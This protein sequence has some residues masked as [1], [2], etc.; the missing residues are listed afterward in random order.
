MLTMIAGKNIEPNSRWINDMAREE[1][2]LPYE[3]GETRL[4]RSE[5]LVLRRQ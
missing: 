3:E 4:P 1:A 2:G 5:K